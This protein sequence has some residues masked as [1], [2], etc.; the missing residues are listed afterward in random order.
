[1]R[2]SKWLHG[3]ILLVVFS[4]ATY[5]AIWGSGFTFFLLR[6]ASP[7]GKVNFWTWLQYW[8]YYRFDPVVAATLKKSAIFS[9][10]L[11]YGV[12]LSLLVPMFFRQR[13]LHGEARF[14]NSGEIRQSGLLGAKRGVLV[15]SWKNRYLMLD[16]QQFVLLAAPT[17]SGKGV[18]VVIPNLLNFSDSCVV[19][20]IKQEN[21]NLTAGFRK[22]H[23]QQVY[24]FN[25]FSESLRTH[26]YNPLAYIRAGNFRVG[27]ILAIARVFYPGDGK[28]PFFDD[29]ARNVFLGIA[30]Y[31][32]ETPQ[33]PRTIGEMLR[34][35]SGKGQPIKRYLQGI[36]ESRNGENQK[37]TI[38]LSSECIDALS[39]FINT[40]DDTRT[41]ILATF[42]APLTIWA[43]PIV[44]AA[45]SDNDFDLRKVRKKRMTIYVGITPD[46]L[47]EASRLVNLF[48]SQLIN[49]NTKELPSSSPNLKYQCLLLLDEF[50]S[51]GKVTI[52]AKAVAYIA[53]YN[54]RLLPIIQSISQL[55]AVYGQE[56]A[57]NFI[58]NHALHILYSPR[59]QKDANEY[60]DMLGY[61]TV[62]SRS[63]NRQPGGRS[64]ESI[65]DQRRALLLPQEIKEIGKWKEIVILE[66]TKPILCDKIKYFADPV[67]KKRLLSAPT[68]AQIDIETYQ[69]KVQSRIRELTIQ[70]VERGIELDKLNIDL[71]KIPNLDDVP[72]DQESVEA[73]VNGFFEAL[74]VESVSSDAKLEEVS[75]TLSDEPYQVEQDSKM[76]SGLGMSI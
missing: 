21:F 55:T 44:D 56:D 73:Y 27:D 37:K 19:L 10:V 20:D 38:P 74:G 71:T 51:M 48:F 16:G 17:R 42:N 35:S 40:S 76:N 58:T 64:S 59:E 23:G 8:E 4:I 72:L 5:V 3:V 6:K 12:A 26:R 41:S 63:K 75:N 65:S 7:W 54:L 18:G 24:L 66:N 43:N 53:A 39:R 50:T 69:A 28:D 62:K 70:D 31:L 52:I 47:S 13:S 29:Q 1:M 2:G 68:I 67:F 57:R 15:G 11:S 30:L 33:L 32:C 45:T 34:Q 22:K 49:L 9:F 46:Y 36:I 14:A 25:P 60:S 61:E